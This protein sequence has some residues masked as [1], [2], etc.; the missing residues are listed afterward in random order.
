MIRRLV[1]TMLASLLV[2]LVGCGV[3]S[4]EIRQEAVPLDDFSELRLHPEAYIGE[5]VIL[6]GQVIETRN[7]P[8]GTTLVVLERPLGLGERPV[9]AN[10]SGGRFL[11]RFP[12]FLD[13]VVFAA[14]R[15]VTV[16]GVVTGTVTEKIGDA[17]VSCVLLD[18]REVHL[19]KESEPPYYPIPWYSPY[20]TW[21]PY[22]YPYWYDPYWGSRPW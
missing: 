1:P 9:Q 19:W 16:A 12:E 4:K 2:A 21:Y 15:K 8:E 11:V 22:W 20:P 7:R 13:P 3:I 6:G 18:G 5:T 17:E 14:G 10:A